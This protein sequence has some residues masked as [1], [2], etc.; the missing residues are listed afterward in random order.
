MRMMIAVLMIGMSACTPSSEPSD[1]TA[2][3]ISPSPAPSETVRK[4]RPSPRETFRAEPDP[5]EIVYYITHPDSEKVD[6]YCGAHSRSYVVEHVD[7]PK[8][9]R[10]VLTRALNALFR[11]GFSA[12]G[13]IGSVSVD[14]ARALLDLRSTHEI[15]FAGASCGGVTFQGS[16]LRTVFQFDHIKEARILLEGSCKAFGEFSQAGKCITF[17]R[18]DL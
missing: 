5:G 2:E 8:S 18:S 4:A 11:E 1:G 3:E 13:T 17:T 16:V 7:I 14:G 10:D 12:D 6:R 15:D 9:Q